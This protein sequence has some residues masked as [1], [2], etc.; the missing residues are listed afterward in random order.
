MKFKYLLILT[1]CSNIYAENLDFKKAEYR[2]E[3][4]TQ[5][6][7]IKIL[8]KI[9]PSKACDDDLRKKETIEFFKKTIKRNQKLKERKVYLTYR[10]YL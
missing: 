4:D 5:T 6:E 10:C 3:F 2:I 1:F 9:K 8:S 7:K